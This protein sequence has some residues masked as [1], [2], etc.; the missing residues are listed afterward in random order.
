MNSRLAVYL[1]WAFGLAVSALGAA[2]F[3]WVAYAAYCADALKGQ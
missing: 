2:F 3:A 1:S